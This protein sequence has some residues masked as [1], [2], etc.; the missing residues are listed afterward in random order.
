MI[1]AIKLRRIDL[2]NFR[3]FE[4]ASIPIE[5][6][7]TVLVARNGGG[8]T[9]VL[10]AAAGALSLWLNEL[11]LMQDKI[12]PARLSRKDVRFETPKARV[13]AAIEVKFKWYSWEKDENEEEETI[14]HKEE[15]V[16]E[17][18][19]EVGK[20]QPA[21]TLISVTPDDALQH[22]TAD[23]LPNLTDQEPMPIFYYY[24]AEAGAEL[25]T[26]PDVPPGETDDLAYTT[27]QRAE[28]LYADA[29]TPQP[30]GFARFY[31]WFDQR[32][33]YELY[34]RHKG[35]FD[36]NDVM[37]QQVRHCIAQLL[38][39]ERAAYDNLEIDY[40]NPQKD[41]VLTKTTSAQP[42]GTP[43]EVARLSSG[44]RHLFALASQIALRLIMA[45]PDSQDPLR[46]GFGIVLIDELDA[47]LHLAW[48][49]SALGK[50]RAAFPKV[51]FIVTTHS[52]LLLSAIPSN[53]ILLIE[54]YQ[55]YQPTATYGRDIST[56]ATQ[57]MDVPGN[58][59]KND[60]SNIFG[61]IARN[62]LAEAENRLE[63]LKKEFSRRN[64]DVSPEF[65]ELR[66]LIDQKM[67]TQ[68]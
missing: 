36:G 62:Q 46:E 21:A 35:Y 28:A 5:Q 57:L 63:L 66:A 10:D 1:T 34:S 15:T 16:F 40:R 3:G 68:V 6:D 25:S 59:L 42:R 27:A 33:T 7:L 13:V 45:N 39:D 18:A 54:D 49:Q 51:Q 47:H 41:M 61:L 31:R 58:S 19:F 20:S 8:K 60:Y 44:E 50:L 2:E 48:Q 37:L 64:E 43:V 38:S 55:A 23:S 12:L 17:V 29:L 26:P 56:I 65:L 30:A 32:S 67:I 52:P 11:K 22:L 53:E 14:E 9:S 4:Q 24:S